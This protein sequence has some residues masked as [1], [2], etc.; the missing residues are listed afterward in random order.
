MAKFGPASEERLSTCH[1]DLQR[2]F[3]RVVQ[4]TDCVVLCGHR[5]ENDQNEAF[6]LGNSKLK[7]PNSK[8]NTTPSQAADVVPFPLDW[9]DNARFIHFAGIVRGVAFEMG[10]DLVWGGDWDRDLNLSEERFKDL[11][12]FE[13]RST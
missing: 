5:G 6:R 9:Q 11:P 7:F 12:H 8:H 3:R 2:L 10:I 4:I 1:P 13:L